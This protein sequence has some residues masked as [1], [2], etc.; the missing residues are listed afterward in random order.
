MDIYDVINVL[1]NEKE[2]IKRNV[3]SCSR[4]CFNCDLVMPDETLLE[5]YNIA[6]DIIE[7][8]HYYLKTH[9]GGDRNG[10]V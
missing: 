7:S 3:S 1:R 6:I 8:Y 4:D 5:A 9:C 10:L 2:C